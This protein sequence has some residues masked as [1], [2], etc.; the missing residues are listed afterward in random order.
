MSQPYARQHVSGGL[1]VH[2]HFGAR[3]SSGAQLHSQSNQGM[4][5]VPSRE[6]NGWPKGKRVWLRD[7]SEVV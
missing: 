6:G 5:S 2:L 3:G 7:V 1:K 4:P